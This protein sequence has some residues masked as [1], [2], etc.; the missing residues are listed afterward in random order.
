LRDSS[1]YQSRGWSSVGWWSVGNSGRQRN[2]PMVAAD[3][4][5]RPP[6]RRAY[7]RARNAG[8]RSAP[9]APNRQGRC[10]RFSLQVHA[11][12]GQDQT[13]K[14]DRHTDRPAER[15]IE[16][17]E[18][19]LKP[20]HRGTERLTCAS[21][22]IFTKRSSRRARC[23]QPDQ[24]CSLASR[25]SSISRQRLDRSLAFTDH[26]PGWLLQCGRSLSGLAPSEP[27]SGRGPR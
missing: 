4:W 18:W 25:R 23:H 1:R 14:A 16:P 2:V 19:C 26:E 7:A 9:V 11:H 22:S 6:G 24:P 27:A 3:Q 10:F 15:P 17:A 12:R 5:S 20:G 13:P 21:Q 8:A